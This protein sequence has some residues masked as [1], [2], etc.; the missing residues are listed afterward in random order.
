[1]IAPSLAKYLTQNFITYY[2]VSWEYNSSKNVYFV[3]GMQDLCF[4]NTQFNFAK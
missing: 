1:M 2:N 3:V 4:F